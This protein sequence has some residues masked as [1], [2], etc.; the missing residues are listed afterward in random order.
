MEFLTW[1]GPSTIRLPLAQSNQRA[2]RPPS[3]VRGAAWPERARPDRPPGYRWCRSKRLRRRVRNVRARGVWGSVKMR[4]GGPSSTIAPLSMTMTRSARSAAKAISCV[5]TS[6]V[7]PSWAS[8]HMTSSTSPTSSGSSAE[9]GSSKRRTFGRMASARA[10]ATRCCWPPD[11]RAGYSPAF[12]GRP[13]R[14]RSAVASTTA[15]GRPIP[16]A[17]IGPSVTFSSAVLW[18]KRW[19]CWNT[20]PTWLRIRAIGTAGSPT[21]IPSTTTR[22]ALTGSRPLMQRSSVLLPDPLGPMITS[23]S[24]RATSTET[25][26]R[27]LSVPKNFV[28]RSTRTIG[29]GA[30]PRAAPTGLT[31]APGRGRALASARP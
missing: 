30:G 27:T 1:T 15:S 23:R 24:P 26:S 3:I 8:C 17:L 2:W 31:R 19:K 5:T 12:S 16:S 18:G 21:A 4:W 25:S 29:S 11:S 6:I 10:M 20:M 28:T 22:P 13:T 14:S 9:V 7:M